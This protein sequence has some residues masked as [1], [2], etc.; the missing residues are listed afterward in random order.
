MH[1]LGGLD[2]YSETTSL[3]HFDFSIGHWFLGGQGFPVLHPQL[4]TWD[5]F[6]AYGRMFDIP[7]YSGK[8]HKTESFWKKSVNCNN[9]KDYFSWEPKKTNVKSHKNCDNT[10]KILKQNSYVRCHFVEFDI[11]FLALL[12]GIFFCVIINN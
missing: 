2:T 9:T 5:G 12:W 4:R 11:Y 7:L 3:F 10:G 6:D 1:K 8:K